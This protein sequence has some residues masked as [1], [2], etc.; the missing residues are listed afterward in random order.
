MKIDTL[1]DWLIV[2]WGEAL[3]EAISNICPLRLHRQISVH[4]GV[5][6]WFYYCRHF[7]SMTCYYN[8]FMVR[9]IFYTLWFCWI[10]SLVFSWIVFPWLQ[11][12]YCNSLFAAR[13]MCPL[14]LGAN[15][16]ILDSI[17]FWCMEICIFVY[18][19]NF[20]DGSVMCPYISIRDYPW[21]TRGG[22]FNA[23][24]YMVSRIS[25]CWFRDS[26]LGHEQA[27]IPYIQQRKDM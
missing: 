7:E 14:L 27:S 5:G 25:N 10:C 26:L 11:S 23:R 13:L 9:S 17:M 21:S 3:P 2:V 22:I 12:G 24:D 18:I 1:F 16:C 19:G 6:V 20:F 4:L 8:C 15:V